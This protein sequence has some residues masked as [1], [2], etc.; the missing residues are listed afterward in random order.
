MTRS[1]RW[2]RGRALSSLLAATM[3]AFFALS[4]C[5]REE[6][7]STAAEAAREVPVV[8]V[9]VVE[10]SVPVNLY[11]IGNVEPYV[12]VALKAQVDGQIVAVHFKAGQDVTEGDLLFELD[13]RPFE[14]QLRQAQANLARDQAQEQNALARA[15]RYDKLLEKQYV[16][17]EEYDQAQA[18]LAVARATI[19]A[20]EAVVGHA[21]LQLDYTKIRSPIT[22]RT[23]KI[24]IQEGNLVK[25]SDNPL[26]VVNQVKPVYVTF[27]VPEHSLDAVREYLRKGTATVSIVPSQPAPAEA[28]P[29]GKLVFLDNAVDAATGTITVRAEFDNPDETLWPGQ[30]V[31]VTLTLY[32]QRDAVVVPADAVQTGPKGQY[33]FVVRPDMTAEMRGVTVERTEGSDS[34]IAQGLSPG[35][36]VVVNG[37]SRLVPGAKVSTESSG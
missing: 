32:E 27:A 9:P 24:L 7:A 1:E 30:F 21:R 16:S 31:N 6:P 20:D 36:Q 23:G 2:C 29:S 5:S 35:E 33:V 11:A 15:R 22:G 8:A 37:Q 17:H 3:V 14:D 28:V 12:T 26:V 4:A 18:D 10:K 19:K 13:P 34:I 25:A